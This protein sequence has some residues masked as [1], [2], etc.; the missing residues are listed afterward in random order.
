M[1][2]CKMD[3]KRNLIARPGRTSRPVSRSSSRHHSATVRSILAFAALCCLADAA[4]AKPARCSTTD[5]G[6][7]ACIF[8]ATGRGGSFEIS[9]PGK[10]TYTLNVAEPDI[11]SGY[12][13]IG[14][15]NVSLPGRYLRSRTERGCWVN[16]ATRAKICAR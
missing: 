6:S 7:F 16:D 14:G 2:R 3:R 11:A 4:D 15:R 5:D 8:R 12:V 13:T 10:P 9:A 1:V